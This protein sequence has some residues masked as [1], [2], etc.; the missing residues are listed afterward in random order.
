MFSTETALIEVSNEW[1]LNINNNFLKGV[2]FLFLKNA[3]DVIDYIDNHA[4]KT[5]TLWGQLSLC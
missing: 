3:F 1:F 5:L 4:G 2:I